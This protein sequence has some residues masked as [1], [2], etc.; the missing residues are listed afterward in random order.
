MSPQYTY[1]HTGN[2]IGVFLPIDDWNKLKQK[3]HDIEN[4]SELPQWQKDILDR[5]LTLLREHPERVQPLEAF[6]QEIESDE[7]I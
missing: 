4:D 2:P 6:L 1:D 3:Y 7:E 5:R